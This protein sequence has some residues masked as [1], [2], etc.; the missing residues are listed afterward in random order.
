MIQGTA[1]GAGEVVVITLLLAGLLVPM[2]RKLALRLGVVDHPVPGQKAHGRPVPYLG[3]AAIA[4]VTLLGAALSG[5]TRVV[6]LV[7]P[8]LLV[9]ALGL[10][11]DVRPLSPGFRVA[12]EAGA[13]VFA[14][15]ITPLHRLYPGWGGAVLTAAFL[16]MAANCFNLMDNS[17]GCAGA[18]GAVVAG[19]VVL[20]GLGLGQQEPVIVA[21]ALAGGLG[22]FLVWNWHPARIFMGDAGSLFIGFLAAELVLSLR[23]HIPRAAHLIGSLIFLAP[24][25]LDTA[26]VVVARLRNGRSI[27]VGG[28]DHTT[29]RL[30]NIGISVPRVALLLAL[31][32]A[33]CVGLGLAVIQGVVGPL[34]A[35][36]V[37]ILAWGGF[38]FELLRVPVAAPRPRIPAALL[39]EEQP[40]G[41]SAYKSAG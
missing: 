2:A 22:G 27:V 12:V 18:V 3:G 33:V 17:D 38:L 19:G 16:I 1:A 26:L 8:A 29:H 13:G 24:V 31:A 36:G 9:A 4:L 39:A 5:Q 35:G 25:L 11:D 28:C 41:A 21:A 14:W 32:S 15:Q 30:R 23:P 7:L 40:A 6:A 20:A 34:M 10:G 37:A